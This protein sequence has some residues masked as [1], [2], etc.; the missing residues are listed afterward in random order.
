ME[1]SGGDSTAGALEKGDGGRP[2]TVD[3]FGV[4]GGGEARGHE[5]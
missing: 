1:F 5:A 4:N 3:F 2:G